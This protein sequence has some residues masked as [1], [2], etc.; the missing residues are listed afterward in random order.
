MA[1]DQVIHKKHIVIFHIPYPHIVT[2]TENKKKNTM[3]KI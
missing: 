3:E 1:D 2:Y